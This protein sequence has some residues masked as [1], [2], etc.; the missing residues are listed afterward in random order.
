MVETP[1]V[2]RK[3]RGVKRTK[4][5]TIKSTSRSGRISPEILPD[6][7]IPSEPSTSKLTKYAT[8]KKGT[9]ASNSALQTPK[10]EAAIDTD[11]EFLGK[12]VFAKWSDNNYYPGKVTEKKPS[13]VNV[14]YKVKFYDGK[15]KDIIQDFILLI[16]SSIYKGLSVYAS[17]ENDDSASCGIVTGTEVIDDVTHFVVETDEDEVLKVLVRDISLTSDQANY[18]RERINLES[19]NLPSTP[20]HLGKVTLDNTVDGKRRSRR[21]ATPVYSGALESKKRGSKSS[22]SAAKVED[23]PV[24]SG[25][26]MSKIQEK[27]V[28]KVQSEVSTTSESESD[29]FGVQPEITSTTNEYSAKG[30]QSKFKGKARSKKKPENLEKTLGPLPKDVNLFRGMSFLVTCT[31]YDKSGKYGFENPDTDPQSEPGTENE[32][33]W[34]SV[35]LVKER[36]EEQLKAGGGTVY[37]NFNQIPEDEYITTKLI[38]NI[39]NTTEK[40]L[41]CLSKGISPYN[42]QWVIRCCQDVSFILLFSLLRSFELTLMHITIVFFYTEHTAQSRTKQASSWL[43]YREAQVY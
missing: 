23:V 29:A 21:N 32:E 42:H 28:G 3:S 8:P 26:G 11:D 35:P 36:I 31:S 24:A 1:K 40:S 16:P 10:A 19:N 4:A 13:N 6:C 17:K 18:A 9:K 22:S 7:E 41:L 20:K 27:S 43:E 37:E 30:P 34:A 14:K 12:E 33:E 25:S 15:S 2:G 5:R 38:T 39:P